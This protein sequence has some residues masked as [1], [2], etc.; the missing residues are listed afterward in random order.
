MLALAVLAAGCQR[1]SG[2]G[3]EATASEKWVRSYDLSPGGEFQ[4]VGGNGSV[5][6]E[7]GSGPKVEVS[8]D[9]ITRAASEAIAR[10]V[11]P[12]VHIREDIAGEKIVLQT[13]SLGGLVFGVEVVVNY[14]VRVPSGTRV[15][16]RAA[17]GHV[18]VKGL[19]ALVSAS[20]ENGDISGTELSRG[21]E[22]RT[23]NGNVTL[24]L[25]AFDRDSIDLRTVNGRIDIGVPPTINANLLVNIVNGNVD[26]AD[27]PW[28]PSTE[29]TTQRHVRGRLNGG[30]S[31]IELGVTNGSIRVHPR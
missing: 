21:I 5:A 11:L 1:F 6:V 3:R 29:R 24:D 12:R 25:A 27:L 30:G 4:I 23:V 26:V 20:A 9:R 16:V 8:A 7:R 15:H 2:S 14:R 22:M 18:S 28:E 31:P 10:E 19:D 13:E 17:N